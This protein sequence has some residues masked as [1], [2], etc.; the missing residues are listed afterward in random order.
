M[1]AGHEDVDLRLLL[2][3]PKIARE[4]I[5]DYN[6]Q[7]ERARLSP[8]KYIVLD[9]YLETRRTVYLDQMTDREAVDA[10]LHMLLNW[11]IPQI[12][13]TLDMLDRERHVH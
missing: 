1:G 7:R 13:E 3:D 12:V 2:R 11:E 4:W 6:R 9:Y 8:L 10:A 5:K